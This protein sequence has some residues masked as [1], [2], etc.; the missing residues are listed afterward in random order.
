[1]NTGLNKTVNPAFTLLLG[2]ADC[3]DLGAALA[4]GPINCR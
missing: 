2:F 3:G 1:M 4:Y